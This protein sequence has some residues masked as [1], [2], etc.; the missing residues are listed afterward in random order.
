MA[1]RTGRLLEKVRAAAVGLSFMAPNGNV[2]M[3][4]NHHISKIV[5]IG[6]VRNDGMFEI[7]SSTSAAVNPLPWNQYVTATKGYACDWSNPKK[8]GKYKA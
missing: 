5:R 1:Y 2:V 7:V 8:G 3:N 6:K 4:G